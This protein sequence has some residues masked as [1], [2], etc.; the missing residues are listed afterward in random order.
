ML[1]SVMLCL[2]DC[3]FGSKMYSKERIDEDGTDVSLENKN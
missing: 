3:L 1:L 2:F